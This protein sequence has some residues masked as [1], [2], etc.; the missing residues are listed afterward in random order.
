MPLCVFDIFAL[1]LGGTLKLSMLF[2]NGLFC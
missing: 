2:K 1:F